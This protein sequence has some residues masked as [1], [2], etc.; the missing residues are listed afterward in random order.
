[1]KAPAWLAAC[2]EAKLMGSEALLLN[3]SLAKAGHP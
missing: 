1:M 3:E 2:R